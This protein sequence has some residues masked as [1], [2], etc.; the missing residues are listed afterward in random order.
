MS[1]KTAVPKPDKPS[2]NK[3]LMPILWSAVVVVVLLVAAAGALVSYIDEA[4]IRQFI[5]Q[6]AYNATG[7]AL[8]INGALDIEIGFSPTIRVQDVRFANA[9]WAQPPYM[10]TMEELTIQLDLFTLFQNKIV[11]QQIGLVKPVVHLQEKPDGQNNW[12]F[13]ADPVPVEEAVAQEGEAVTTDASTPRIPVIQSL[14]VT[15]GVFVYK[16]AN[17]EEQR[18]TVALFDVRDS[19][20]GLDIILKTMLN[21]INIDAKASGLGILDFILTG[22]G[23]DATINALVTLPSVPPLRVQSS[24]KNEGEKPYAL[25]LSSGK[26]QIEAHTLGFAGSVQ[27]P[28]DKEL[29]GNLEVN[30]NSPSLQQL[31]V[32]AGVEGL[33]SQPLTA[34]IKL[35]FSL[36]EIKIDALRATLGE[37]Q[38]TG[39]I[40]LAMLPDRFAIDAATFTA[41]T[42]RLRDMLMPPVEKK[43]QQ[44]AAKPTPSATTKEPLFSDAP[45]TLPFF[46]RSDTDGR[47]SVIAL[48]IGSLEVKPFLAY[49]EPL[50]DITLTITSQDKTLA[51]TLQQQGV[52]S[53]Q[54]R[55]NATR[56]VPVV[57]A[58]LDARLSN[59][60]QLLTQLEM[61]DLVQDGATAV[62]LNLQAEGQSARA[63]ANTLKGT[64]SLAINEATIANRYVDVLAADL[65]QQVLPWAKQEDVTHLQCLQSSWA[66]ANGVA[67]STGTVAATRRIAAVA[68][69]TVNLGQERI[70]LTIN[71]RA[72][73]RSLMSLGVPIRVRGDLASPSVGLD[74]G[75]AIQ[76]LATTLILGAI[77]P[78]AALAPLVQAGSVDGDDPCAVMLQAGGRG[79]ANDNRAEDSPIVPK[80]LEKPVNQ[81]RNFLQRALPQ[82]KPAAENAPS[83]P[84]TA[85]MDE[86][87]PDT[88][89]LTV[90]ESVAPEES[91]IES[92]APEAPAS[93]PAALDQEDVPQE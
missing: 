72:R 43:A 28:V 74:A 92:L 4:R 93:A 44:A 81:L 51:A 41:P 24:M 86:V 91:P 52:E 75:S 26:A 11:V 61:T 78:V 76:G 63:W 69:G 90:D 36:P 62:T 21:D 20:R 71:P 39:T 3:T 45:I 73:D 83:A 2:K 79:A 14:R 7:R 16:A 10:V 31:G 67:T 66:I 32:L 23:L 82:E 50:T 40:A 22:R 29:Q 18:L 54:L 85:P 35:A 42:L 55:Y 65:V 6:A 47:G 57:S 56:R 34:T 17:G 30:L 84:T 5:T 88:A 68:T 48:S 33:A 59:L 70:D 25:L 13:S 27:L 15:D 89:P 49:P 53:V 12:T 80:M 58:N 8:E 9:A 38:L 19:Y 60:G 64:A 46:D 77:N 37:S 87:A 1:E